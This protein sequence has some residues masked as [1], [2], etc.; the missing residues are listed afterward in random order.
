[1][2]I[3]KHL[4]FIRLKDKGRSL[5]ANKI[6]KKGEIV[7]RF[8]FD[9][10]SSYNKASNESVQIDKDKFLDSKYYYASDFINH[11]CYANTKIDFESMNF[12]SLRDIKK[13]EEITY[14][15][16]TTEYDLIRDNLDFDC[17]CG[18][19]K[20]FGRIKGFK[21]LTDKQKEALKPLL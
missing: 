7:L 15:Y 4:K 11:G 20:C 6:I 5:F 12:V 17:K 13:G 8:G 3:P 18:S 19:K 2:R 1:M 14:N 9:S 21:F 10:I 16:L